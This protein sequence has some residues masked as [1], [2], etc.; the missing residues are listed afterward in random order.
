MVGA[1]GN[2]VVAVNE[3]VVSV[4]T[5][6][7][8]GHVI[9]NGADALRKII[10]AVETRRVSPRTGSC[11]EVYGDAAVSGWGWCERGVAAAS[12]LMRFVAVFGWRLPLD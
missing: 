2:V 12:A 4:T 10:D 11:N 8:M 1:H 7:M 9:V 6:P 3:C 5:L